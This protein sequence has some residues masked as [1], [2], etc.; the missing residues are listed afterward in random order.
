MLRRIFLSP[1]TAYVLLVVVAAGGQI[2]LHDVEQDDIGRNHAQIEAIA[3]VQR[4]IVEVGNRA[5]VAGCEGQN[6]LRVSLAGFMDSTLNRATRV[7]HATLSDPLATDE[8]KA[9]A[10]RNL[11]GLQE[12]VDDLH[13]RLGEQ[14]CSAPLK[15]RAR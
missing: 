6:A 8:Q 15:S 4:Q 3:A 2:R 10:T 5:I 9:T 7:A 14:A 12:I 1:V 13:A 11:A